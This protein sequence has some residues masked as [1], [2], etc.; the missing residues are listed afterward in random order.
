MPYL[1]ELDDDVFVDVRMRSGVVRYLHVG[2]G[3]GVV[4]VVIGPGPIQQRGRVYIAVI[5]A[6][7]DKVR[8]NIPGNIIYFFNFCII[9]LKA[10][11][12]NCCK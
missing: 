10:I 12:L 7:T 4:V 6:C 11:I 8:V 1:Q 5:I 2:Y 3:T 9:S